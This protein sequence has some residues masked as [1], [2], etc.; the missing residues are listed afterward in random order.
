MDGYEHPDAFDDPRISAPFY[1]HCPGDD[2]D[3]L[4]L[5]VVHDH[6]ASV[7]RV[8]TVLDTLEPTTVALELP[9][10]AIPLYRAYATR[11]DEHDHPRTGG[12]MSAAIAATDAD[13][14]GIDA[15]S[16]SFLRRLVTR[17][18]ADR[19]PLS[20]VR[21][22]LS[23]VGGA[24][25]TAL[26]CR[27]AATMS[28]PSSRCVGV[29]DTV[30]YDVAVDDPP[31]TQAAHE[32]SHVSGV[33]ALLRATETDPKRYRDETREACMADHLDA[34]RADGDVVAV[35]GVDHLDPLADALAR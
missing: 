30:D 31:A 28:D 11:L 35:V 2:G 32:R 13:V 8:E 18:V 9:S 21:R 15:P 16:W 22:V 4:L 5:G 33:T 14:A 3:V 19:V 34:L 24:T 1:R 25:R 23:S 29:T 10:A 6:P 12:E 17:L 27:L 7:G 26:A 20:T